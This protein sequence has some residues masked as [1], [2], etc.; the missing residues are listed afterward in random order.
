MNPFHSLRG[1]AVLLLGSLLAAQSLTGTV[2]DVRSTP[3][4][5]VTITL[6]NNG[7]TQVTNALGVFTFP[8]LQNRTYTVTV[9]PPT[10]QL[11]PLQRSFTVAGASNMGNVVVQDAAAVTG[12]VLGPTGAPLSGAN[13]D[14]I[15]GAG[16]TVF[17]PNDGTTATGT[18]SIT[19]PLGTYRFRVNPP[20]GQTLIAFET[21]ATVA[22]PLS[23]GTIQLAQAFLVTGSVVDAVTNVPIAGVHVATFDNVTNLEIDQTTPTTNALGAFTMRL[24]V[25]VFRLEFDPPTGNPHAAR[26]K[27]SVLV[28]GATN[29][30]LIGLK[31]AITLTGTV[32]GP[33][34][35]IALC[36]IDVLA[37]DGNK[38][39]TL[40]DNTNA[41][42]TF[43]AVVPPGDYRIRIDPPLG[44]GLYG[45]RT[46]LQ[47]YAISGPL[48]PVAL[49]AGVSLQIG[50]V[51]P[52]GFETNADLDFVDVATGE[53]LILSGDKSGTNG[54]I[55]AIVP[56][57]LFE[58]AIDAAQG[59]KA[60]PFRI[61]GSISGPLAVP[62]FLGAKQAVLDL[63]PSFGIQSIAQGGSLFVDARLRNLL[64][65]DL[66]VQLELAIRFPSGQ[67]QPLGALP[68]DLLAGFDFSVSQ[69]ELP[70]AAV[71]TT[72]LGKDLRLYVR[73]RDGNQ[74]VLDQAYV[75]FVV[76]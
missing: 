16:L 72:E 64:T 56:T 41:A 76:E 52:D 58:I 28:L 75:E 2:L 20:A 10:T 59:S 67:E 42:G 50:V 51:G 53:P 9:S 30:G 11:A 3:V 18:F 63:K 39:F 22:G 45:V 73:F 46:P 62:L 14:A 21:T 32:S 36:D 7:G 43:T 19:V 29:L 8:V 54:I 55:D 5:G 4:A 12:I 34:G 24:P 74:Q 6:S 17:T 38:V 57:G 69:F 71:P 65:I 61:Q 40:H 48:A 13:L 15:D 68:I 27:H 26:Q 25:G 23:L 35:P 1:I 44:S 49:Q 47:T 66:P 70:I 33:A 37:A 60:A 31:P